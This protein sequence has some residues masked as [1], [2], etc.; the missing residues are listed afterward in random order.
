M[1]FFKVSH[2]TQK[3]VLECREERHCGWMDGWLNERHREVKKKGN[4]RRCVGDVERDTVT[5][6][7]NSHQ[8]E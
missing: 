3:Y 6:T 1:A 2:I 8:L 4:N 7:P 5:E